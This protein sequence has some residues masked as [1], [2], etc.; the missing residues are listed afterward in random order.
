MD[1]DDHGPINDSVAALSSLWSWNPGSGI[2]SQGN[3]RPDIVSSSESGFENKIR[4]THSD[5][6]TIAST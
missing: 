1:R 3:H 6:G 2:S 4:K 5:G